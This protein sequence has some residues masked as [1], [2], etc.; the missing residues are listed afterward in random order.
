[1]LAINLIGGLLET[2]CHLALPARDHVPIQNVPKSF[3]TFIY[4]LLKVTWLYTI[5]YLSIIR[6]HIFIYFLRSWG[7]NS[8]TTPWATL[9]DLFLRAHAHMCVRF[10]PR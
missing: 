9:T 1:M 7:L 5:Q 10:F 3:L 8:G 6:S 2:V 4:L